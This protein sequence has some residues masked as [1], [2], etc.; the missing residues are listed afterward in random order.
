[1][2]QATPLTDKEVASFAGFS[3][4][5]ISYKKQTNP[6]LYEIIRLGTTCKKYE[7]NEAELL[8]YPCLERTY[9]Y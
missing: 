4:Q 7:I 5:A 8:A 2:K 6:E 1:M 3:K 9:M